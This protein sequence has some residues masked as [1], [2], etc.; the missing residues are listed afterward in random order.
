[1]AEAVGGSGNRNRQEVAAFEVAEDAMP[2][3]YQDETKV[4]PVIQ[5]PSAKKAQGNS[6]RPDQPTKT[7]R[8]RLSQSSTTSNAP[9]S[10]RDLPIAMVISYPLNMT[11]ATLEAKAL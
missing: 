3:V 2:W 8:S 10:L 5:P 6:R 1:M 11:M 4:V 7:N 9:R